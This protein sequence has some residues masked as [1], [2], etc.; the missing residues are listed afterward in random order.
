[1]PWE[2]LARI[3]TGKAWVFPVRFEQIK[4]AVVF[5]VGTNRYRLIGRV[6]YPRKLYVLR[7]MDHEEYDR[8]PWASQCG[9]HSPPPKRRTP[10]TKRPAQTGRPRR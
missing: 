4:P 1:M 6:F 10:P 7:V 5:D 8:V 3:G 9:C 2:Y